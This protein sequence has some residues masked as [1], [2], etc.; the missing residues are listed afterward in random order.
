MLGLRYRSAKGGFYCLERASMVEPDA[1]NAARG[2]VDSGFEH[3]TS[4]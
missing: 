2:V 1:G 4:G 3:K